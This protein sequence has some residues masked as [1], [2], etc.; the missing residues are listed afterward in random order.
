MSNAPTPIRYTRNVLVM[1]GSFSV[2]MSIG[3]FY[4]APVGLAIIVFSAT[5]L[6]LLSFIGLRIMK[7]WS[8]YI[9]SGLMLICAACYSFAMFQGENVDLKRLLLGSIIPMIFYSV[10]IPY[11]HEFE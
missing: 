2:L 10:V 11:W 5:L 1:I 8:V 7:K 9:F 3:E 6:M 4:I